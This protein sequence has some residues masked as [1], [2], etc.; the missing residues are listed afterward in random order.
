MLPDLAESLDD[1]AGLKVAEQLL[2][3]AALALTSEQQQNHC[4]VVLARHRLVAS[5]GNH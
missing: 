2:D 1:I 5:Q 3:L 4:P